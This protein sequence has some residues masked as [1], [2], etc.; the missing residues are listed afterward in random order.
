[1]QH[2]YDILKALC[3]GYNRNR[4]YTSPEYMHIRRNYVSLDSTV[5]ESIKVMLGI[6]TLANVYTAKENGQTVYRVEYCQNGEAFIACV[7]TFDGLAQGVFHL[8]T[9]FETA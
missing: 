2:T 7:D 9:Q 3:V 4:D 1:M 8:A 5:A 6:H